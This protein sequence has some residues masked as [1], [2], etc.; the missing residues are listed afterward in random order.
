M[1]KF[2]KRLQLKSDAGAKSKNLFFFWISLHSDS[3]SPPC[4]QPPTP[5]QLLAH[6][7][8][9]CGELLDFLYSVVLWRLS[10]SSHCEEEFTGVTAWPRPLSTFLPSNSLIVSFRRLSGLS[11]TLFSSVHLY[12]PPLLFGQPQTRRGDGKVILFPAGF[13]IGF[14]GASVI[15]IEMWSPG[16]WNIQPQLKLILLSSVD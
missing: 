12:F 15:L 1:G 6:Q 7:P 11:R 13:N 14:S 10:G 2:V 3:T 8:P 4:D 9:Y 5:H 16:S